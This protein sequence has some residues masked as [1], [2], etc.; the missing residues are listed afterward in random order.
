MRVFQT[1][2]VVIF[3]LLMTSTHA[4]AC[5]CASW[6]GGK[7]SDFAKDYT[8]FWGVPIKSEVHPNAGNWPGRGVD[9]KIKIID[10]FNFV[11]KPEI[12]VSSS[13]PHGGTCGVELTMGVAQFI[14]AF[15]YGGEDMYIGEC[16]PK[17]PYAQLK[18]YLKTG[19]DSY[20]PAL[21]DCINENSP[22]CTV[23]D[24]Y[25]ADPWKRQGQEDTRLYQKQWYSE[26]DES[27]DFTPT[28][29]PS[30]P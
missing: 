29:V 28:K 24:D 16:T 9:Y 25:L 20:I 6:E 22:E 10:A 1:L 27:L 11:T 4:F 21:D 18:H 5:S 30:K 8:S 14:S 15:S 3:T 23:W 19:E 17:I 26:R 2:A 12:T 7:V 13:I